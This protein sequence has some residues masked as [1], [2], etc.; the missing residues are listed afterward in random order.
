MF[1]LEYERPK[2]KAGS[3]RNS[4]DI[5]LGGGGGRMSNIGG[6]QRGSAPNSRCEEVLEQI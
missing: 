3:E 1:Y 6:A 5:F 2:T 4:G